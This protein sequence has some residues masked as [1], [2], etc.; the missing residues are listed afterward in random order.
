[1]EEQLSYVKA[2][3]SCCLPMK[4]RGRT[5]KCLGRD[6]ELFVFISESIMFIFFY[7]GVTCRISPCHHSSFVF[8]S[9]FSLSFVPFRFGLVLVCLLNI[10]VQTLLC[11]LVSCSTSESLM[12]PVKQAPQKAPSDTEGLVNSVPARSHQVN[13]SCCSSPRQDSP[14]AWGSCCGKPPGRVGFVH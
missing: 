9:F 8:V 14:P 2:A 13:C 3:P 6:G 1:M 7:F 11:H 10:V 12:S 5:E 4:L